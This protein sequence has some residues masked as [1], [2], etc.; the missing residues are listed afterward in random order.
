M[1]Y[2]KYTREILA[3]KV[4]E[5][6]SIRHL[7]VLLGKNPSG[8]LHTHMKRLLRVYEI[9]T[10][11]FTF[12]RRNSEKS[13]SKRRKPEEILVVM[14]NPSAYREK[15]SL[16]VRAMVESG[17]PYECKECHLTEWRGKPITLDVD[18][19]DGNYLDN[20]KENLRFLCPNC[21]RQ[22]P[23]FGRGK[24]CDD[25]NKIC[26][27]GEIKQ[28]KSKTC[29]SC[30]ATNRHNRENLSSAKNVCIDCG[31]EI[32]PTATRCEEHYH[33]FTKG[34]RKPISTNKISWPTDDE[35]LAKLRS[36]NYYRLGKELGVSDNAI[37]KRVKSL[38]YNPKTLEK[39]DG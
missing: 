23:T 10:S 20:R 39:V 19:I 36:S 35:L 37:R 27:C 28:D 25:N 1:T 5:A 11:H 30:Y 26:E 9:D 32:S 38:G 4:K 2:T 16:L 17:I 6:D 14:E 24:N 33:A 7:M 31:I 21:H 13:S 22:T 8:G 29:A 15:S 18:H 3:E 34:K 12:T